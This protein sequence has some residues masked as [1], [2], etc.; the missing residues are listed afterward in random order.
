[1]S[2]QVGD[3]APD[4][5][6]PTSD[7]NTVSLR[8]LRGRKVVLYFYP[9]DDTPGCTREACAFR[10]GFPNFSGA[11]AVIIGVSR[12]DAES[13]RKFR[14]KFGLNFPLASDTD[15]TVVN[16]YE[17]WKE[18]NNYGN[19]Y[20]GIERTTYLIDENG[21]IQAIWPKVQVDGHADAVLAAIK[22]EP[23]PA[24]AAPA[25]KPAAKK[26]APK[27]AA[28]KAARKKAPARKAKAAKGAAKKSKKVAKKKAAKKAKKA[29]K[30]KRKA[31]KKKKS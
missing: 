10:D 29:K 31:A 9:K 18:K 1:M 16:D 14:D 12:D 5:S 2:L 17:V 15:G 13:H 30:A 8:D 11:N 22:G 25:P 7:G 23:A 19:V 20:W 3:L 28:K 4:F 24:P 26:A 21:M 27:M 6:M